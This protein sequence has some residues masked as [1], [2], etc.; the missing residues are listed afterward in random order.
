MP[1]NIEVKDRDKS[2]TILSQE[3]YEPLIRIF[4]SSNKMAELIKEP[5]RRSRDSTIRTK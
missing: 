5:T 1:S 2:M 4:R 3:Q